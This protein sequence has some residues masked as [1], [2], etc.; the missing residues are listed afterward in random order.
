MLAVLQVRGRY[1]VIGQDTCTALAVL[2]VKMLAVLQVKVLR[3]FLSI[4][5]VCRDREL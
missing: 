4:L 1:S 2:Q 5:K 3:A